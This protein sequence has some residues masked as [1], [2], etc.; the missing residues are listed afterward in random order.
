MFLFYDA[1][2]LYIFYVSIFSDSISP[3]ISN[4]VP[5]T[6]FLSTN[7]SFVEQKSIIKIADLPEKEKKVDIKE[8]ENTFDRSQNKKIYTFKKIARL[9]GDVH[10][11]PTRLLF[12]LIENIASQAFNPI[13]KRT[14]DDSC[15]QEDCS[16]YAENP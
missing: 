13:L 7:T 11:V 5:F 3:S 10:N 16:I 12:S 4:N 2:T 8:K 6:N 9:V 15:I 14:L 1:G